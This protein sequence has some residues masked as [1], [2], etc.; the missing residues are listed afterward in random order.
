MSLYNRKIVK[1]KKG[2]VCYLV[3]FKRL[4]L[5]KYCLNKNK[6]IFIL[7]FSFFFDYMLM[8]RL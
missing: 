2:C 4:N 3:L 8:F 1:K 5:I 7:E 6:Y